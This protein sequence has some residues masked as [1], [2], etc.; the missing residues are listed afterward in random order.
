MTLQEAKATVGDAESADPITPAGGFPKPRRGDL[1]KKDK[2]SVAD[3][4]EDTVK[5]PQ[6]TNT[7]GIHEMLSNVLGDDLSEE[8]KEKTVTIF[9]AAL[10]EKI[11][12]LEEEFEE[13]YSEKLA[14]EVEEI[15]ETLVKKIDSYLEYVVN[16]WI[17]ENKVALETGYKVTV[18]ESLIA[19]MKDLLESHNLELEESDLDAVEEA[20][21][22]LS[23]SKEKYNDLAR[24]YLE[25]KEENTLLEQRLAFASLTEGMTDT[26]AERLATLAESIDT[27]DIEEFTTKLEMIKESYFDKSGKKYLAEDVSDQLESPKPEKVQTQFDSVARAASYL[28]RKSDF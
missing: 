15:T 5:T 16:E 20:E 26:D 10:H 27:D 22:A 9:E 3:D 21:A 28:D 7:A 17:E 1:F 12:K 18:A 8:F 2:L 13:A 24:K 14:E 25:I 4:I 23:E 11:S 19:G 6:G